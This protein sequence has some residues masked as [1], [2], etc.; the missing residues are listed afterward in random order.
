MQLEELKRLVETDISKSLMPAHVLLQRFNMLDDG[1]RENVMCVDPTYFPFYYH[2][3]KHIK[4]KRMI[5][6]GFGLGLISGSFISSCETVEEFFAFQSEKDEHTW[7]TGRTNILNINL[8][9]KN[10]FKIGVGNFKKHA[11]YISSKK[12]DL[13]LMNETMSYDDYRYTLDILWN[14]IEFDGYMVVDKIMTQDVCRKGFKDLTKTNNR[15]FVEL[16]TL[17]GTGIIKK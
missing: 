8:N 9:L 3:G 17:Y 2:L 7:R 1:A 4:P 10:N 15:E 12:W 16:K 5:E 13:V 6:V 11:F 14:S